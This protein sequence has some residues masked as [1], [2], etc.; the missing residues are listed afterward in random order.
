M[1]EGTIKIS[2]RLLQKIVSRVQTKWSS[3]NCWEEEM[4]LLCCLLRAMLCIKLTDNC[5]SWALHGV[6]VPWMSSQN[7][8]YYFSEIMQCIFSLFVLF[9]SML[10]LRLFI[11]SS[12]FVYFSL[13]HLNTCS[14]NFNLFHFLLFW[15]KTLK[16]KEIERQDIMSRT[17]TQKNCKITFQSRNDLTE[18]ESTKIFSWCF[19]SCAKY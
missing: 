7:Y 14:L 17:Q 12:V 16:K 3:M 13:I 9:L 19:S 4:E 15:T 5:S 11:S 8:F 2:M 6:H 1:N 18:D 10:S